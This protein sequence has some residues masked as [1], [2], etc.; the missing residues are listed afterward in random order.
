MHKYWKE[1]KR[2]GIEERDNLGWSDVGGML[3]L[4]R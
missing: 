1:H 2:K 4:L 3:S